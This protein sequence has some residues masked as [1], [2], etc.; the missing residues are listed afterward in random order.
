MNPKVSL[1]IGIVCI[2]FS[3][4]FVKL[5]EAAPLASGFYRIFIAWLFLAPYCIFGK[6]LK[7]GYKD[8]SVA[9]LGGV[10]FGAD[11]AVWNISLM[12]ISATISTLIA[13]LAPVWVGLLSFLILRKKSGLL[14]WIGTWVAIGGMVILVGV[15]NILHLQF[16][17]GLIY[18]LVASLFYAIYIMITK[19]ILQKI[20]T[21]TFMF[22]NMLGASVFLLAICSYQHTEML[23]FS[24][25][26]WLNLLGMGLICQLA[27]WITINYAINHMEATRVSI[28]LLSQTVIAG[29]WAAFFLNETLAIK[30][31]AGSIIVLAGIAVTFLKKK[32]RLNNA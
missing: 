26:T 2:S 10:V 25:A 31:I 22:Y 15:H 7:I 21:V 8:L 1:I 4:I 23:H 14:F 28:A 11:I 16:N 24:T 12:K 13:N 17:I 32:N 5:A 9:L 29:I 18:A 30:E 6:K 19:G 27:G 20:T 3:P